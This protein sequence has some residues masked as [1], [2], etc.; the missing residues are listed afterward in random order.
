MFPYGL[1]PLEVQDEVIANMPLGDVINYCLAATGCESQVRRCYPLWLRL[2]DLLQRLTTDLVYNFGP[3]LVPASLLRL[4]CLDTVRSLTYVTIRDLDDPRIKT[5]G[6]VTRTDLGTVVEHLA[7]DHRRD[8][9]SVSFRG[10]LVKIYPLSRVSFCDHLYSFQLERRWIIRQMHI[11]NGNAVFEVGYWL[12]PTRRRPEDFT[13]QFLTYGGE[14]YGGVL[15]N[16]SFLGRTA[17]N[18]NYIVAYVSG[19]WSTD[20]PLAYSQLII[21]PRDG[22]RYSSTYMIYSIGR[23]GDIALDGTRLGMLDYTSRGSGAS[24]RYRLRSFEVGN[25]DLPLIA[26][27]GEAQLTLIAICR[28]TL[29]SQLVFDREFDLLTAHRLSSF[30]ERAS[31]IEVGTDYLRVGNFVASFHGYGKLYVAKLSD[32]ERVEIFRVREGGGV[33]VH[34]FPSGGAHGELNDGLFLHLSRPNH[35]FAGRNLIYVWLRH[36]HVRQLPA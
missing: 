17:V 12:L 18:E 20:V 29:D 35:Y 5:R 4:Q 26:I 32:D 1:L 36:L 3:T 21:V 23:G 7:V 30:Y 28:L 33:L 10:N 6:H 19:I 11:C 31:I 34:R 2:S 27:N 14:N 13:L 24:R 15:A 9:I 16:T 25:P 22:C 8:L